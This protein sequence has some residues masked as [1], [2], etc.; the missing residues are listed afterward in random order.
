MRMLTALLMLA[1]AGCASTGSKFIERTYSAPDAEGKQYVTDE[2]VVKNRTISP[3]F[4][5][6]SLA[7][8]NMLAEIGAEGEWHLEVGATADLEG[9]DISAAI[10]ALAS[11]AGEITKLIA[12]LEGAP[13][14]LLE[15]LAIPGGNP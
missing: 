10:Q 13:A 11:L 14:P 2:T 7:N 12:V 9:G 15:P 4:G 8:H 1:L 6:K 5:G 3:P